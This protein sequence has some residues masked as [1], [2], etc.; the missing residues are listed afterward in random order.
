MHAIKNKSF[1][2]VL[3]LLTIPNAR[4]DP[5]EKNGLGNTSIHLAVKTR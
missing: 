1:E 2:A 5:F 4:F 3:H